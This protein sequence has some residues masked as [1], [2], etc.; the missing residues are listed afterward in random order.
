MTK[1]KATKSKLSVEDKYRLYED[2]VQCHEA[3]IDFIRDEYKKRFNKEPL[4]FREDFG[5]TAAMACD[6]TKISPDHEAYGIDLDPEP[7][8]YGIENHFSKLTEDQKSRMH[9]IE[10]N[11]LTPQKFKADITVAFNF[12]Y[13]IFKERKQLIDYFKKVREG[14]NKEGLFFIDLFGGSD[15]CEPLEEA[16]EHDDHTYYWDCDKFNPLTNEVLYYI[17]FKTHKDKVKHERVF[18]YDW[19]M[20][21]PMELREIMY[22]AGFS[23]VDTFWEGTDDDGTGDGNFYVSEEEENCESWVIYMC[24]R[25]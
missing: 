7:I 19:R 12:S 17:H 22:E 23:K 5:G 14:L 2:S 18:T 3:D 1:K 4:I 6:W 16:T 10:D 24:A 13:F 25:P 20:W 11:V 15:C 9:Y 8:K 21:S